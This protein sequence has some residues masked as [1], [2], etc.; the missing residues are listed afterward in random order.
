MAT[1]TQSTHIRV[2]EGREIPQPGRW[3]L[4]PVH[5][6][7]QLVARHLMV[8]KVRGFFRQFAGTL[9]IADEDGQPDPVQMSIID[10]LKSQSGNNAI[11]GPG[12]I[13]VTNNSATVTGA[14]T[15]FSAADV[16]RRIIIKGV[17]YVIKSVASATSIALSTSYQA[18]SDTDLQYA[19]GGVLVGQSWEI[20]L[21]TDLIK[22]DAAT[23]LI[24]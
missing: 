7:I 14:G 5:S 15:E 20:V 8:S 9:V 3:A 6:Q 1:S 19:L 23:G 18:A 12:T 10:E 11:D 24:G 21:P 22:I 17:T 2:V 4:D 16:N 13:N